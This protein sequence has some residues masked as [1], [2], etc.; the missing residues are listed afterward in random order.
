[1]KMLH[2]NAWN[3]ELPLVRENSVVVE[4][5]M[6]GSPATLY[7]DFGDGYRCVFFGDL[8]DVLASLK[9]AGPVIRKGKTWELD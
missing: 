7:T 4:D 9:E 8:E 6:Y 1:M 5:K 2:R 3:Y